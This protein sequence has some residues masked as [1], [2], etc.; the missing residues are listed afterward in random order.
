MLGAWCSWLLGNSQPSGH[1][2][3]ADQPYAIGITDDGGIALQQPGGGIVD[4]VGMSGGSAFGEGSRLGQL[5][6]NTNR[7]YEP[8]GADTDNNAGNFALP[9]PS[10]LT[11][12]GGGCMAP[13][14]VTH[15][16]V[17]TGA[18]QPST[19]NAGELVLLLATVTPGTDPTSTGL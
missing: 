17:L 9:N 13:S 10:T 6:T 1:T 5:T 19:V 18:A 2:G 12:S 16:P 3:P 14:A 11:T 7:S 4:S 15:A 8:V